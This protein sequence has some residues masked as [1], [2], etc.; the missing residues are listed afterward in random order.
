MEDTADNKNLYEVS[1]Y[2]GKDDFPHQPI[3]NIEIHDSITTGR[4]GLLVL[5]GIQAFII[6]IL[7][8]LL[9]INGVTLT[10][11]NTVDM[12]DST[13]ASTGA[14]T[15]GLGNTATDNAT[16]QI[17]DI[18]RR[19][20]S[21]KANDTMYAQSS[22][23]MLQGLSANVSQ[24][25]Q[26]L[27]TTD[28]KIDDIRSMGYEQMGLF[29]NM[30]DYLYQ[31]LQ[32][33]GQSAQRLV[34]IVS[35]LSNIKDTATSAAGVTDDILV[36]VEEL[37][38]L[39]NVSSLFN[40]LTPVSCKDVKVV[41]PNSPSGWYNLNNQNTYCNM[42]ELCSSGGG[43]T[44]LAYLDMSDATQNCPSGFNTYNSGGVRACGRHTS[45]AGCASV[46]YPSN[47][48]SYSQVCGRVTGYQYYSTDAFYGPSDINS[49]YVDGV[50]ITRGSPRQHVWTLAN[51]ITDTYNNNPSI[52]CPCATGSS[53]TV[54]SFVGSHYF[55]ESGN[56]ASGWL[57]T[58]YT[59][60]P[61]WDGQGC[62]VLEASCCSAPGIPWFHRDYG[63]TTT[64]DYIEL[65][66]CSDQENANEDSPVGFYEIYVK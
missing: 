43:W 21:Y 19:I 15:G 26:Q 61:L 35:T 32:T 5:V 4:K 55:C 22:A 63:N 37:L 16:A 12:C 62:G 41:L 40:S 64:T 14:S 48:I 31:V 57:S 3:S 66:V 58:L 59:S 38:Q 10:H 33:T 17:L 1:E 50:S 34:N 42:E 45:G 7:I 60:D 44:R 56:H 8:I 2:D 36:I 24:L 54:P 28:D 29:L 27:G 39:Q 9:G 11:L 46:T 65:R 51:G 20:L 53:Q 52:I 13:G 6:L 47:G 18:T 49:Y 25:S 30:S 23:S